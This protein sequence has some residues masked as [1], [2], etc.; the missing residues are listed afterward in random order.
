MYVGIDAYVNQFLNTA[1]MNRATK[2]TTKP[3]KDME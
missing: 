3:N 1:T 2:A